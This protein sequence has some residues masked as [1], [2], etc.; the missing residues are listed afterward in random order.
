MSDQLDIEHQL[1]LLREHRRRLAADL[2]RFRLQGGS[3]YAD[4]VVVNGIADERES[5]RSTKATLRERGVRCDD[6]PGDEP[7][8]EELPR[9]PF[10]VEALP[11]DFVPRPAE[12]EALTAHLLEER[13]AGQGPGVIAI[14][15][16]GDYGKTTLARAIC[17][18]QRARAKLA[19]TNVSAILSDYDMLPD[20]PDARLV[21]GAL[22]LSSH[23]LARDKTQLAGQLTGRQLSFE[24]QD[25]QA[26]VEQAKQWRGAPW[27]R[28]L[29][30]CLMR[31]GGPLVRTLAGH[32][33]VV[34]AVALTPDGGRPSPP[35]SMAR[36]SC[37]I[38]P[39]ER[40]SLRSKVMVRCAPA[41]HR[42]APRSSR[43]IRRAG[44]ASCTWRPRNKPQCKLT[45]MSSGCGARTDSWRA[46]H[47]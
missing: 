33:D 47:P 18:D 42:T 45:I 15:G 39:A 25:I 31:P 17:H 28:P 1:A 37:G 27:L 11:P 35:P 4:P 22:R 5:I 34:K 12:F 20:D 14:H 13:A 29:T 30:A 26:L 41:P 32:T 21:Q 23:I 9:V 24:S 19:A 38:W 44:S 7:L 3:A 8:P 6:E 46:M 43:A 16:A 40:A 10:M 36:S 2:K